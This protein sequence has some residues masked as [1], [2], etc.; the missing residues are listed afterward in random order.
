MGSKLLSLSGAHHRERPEG[1]RGDPKRVPAIRPPDRPAAAASGP[2]A[3]DRARDDGWDAAQSPLARTG[4][5]PED[6][7]AIV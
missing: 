6:V 2:K 5:A 1:R 7:H 3:H 4:V